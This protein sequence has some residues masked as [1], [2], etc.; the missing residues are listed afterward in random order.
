MSYD[1]SQTS[2]SLY[3]DL[4]VSVVSVGHNTARTTINSLRFEFFSAVERLYIGLLSFDTLHSCRCLAMFWR[5]ST[6]SEVCSSETLEST[7]Q[8]P[9]CLILKRLQCE[10][11][12]GV[13]EAMPVKSF[14]CCLY[15]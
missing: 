14:F 10:D 8:N 13:V 12:D 6:E 9:R 7:F 11:S 4:S 3:F 1:P 5:N 15:K 2:Q